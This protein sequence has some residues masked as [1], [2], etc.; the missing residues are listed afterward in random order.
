MTVDIIERAKEKEK[1]KAKVVTIA[2]NEYDFNIISPPELP[3]DERDSLVQHLLFSMYIKAIWKRGD[4]IIEGIYSRKRNRKRLLVN[5]MLRLVVRTIRRFAKFEAL[6]SSMEGLLFEQVSFLNT[7]DEMPFMIK[8]NAMDLN[9]THVYFNTNIWEIYKYEKVI[10]FD[11]KEEVSKKDV[12]HLLTYFGMVDYMI[13]ELK[14]YLLKNIRG[15]NFFVWK[16]RALRFMSSVQ[17]SQRY[18]SATL[19]DYLAY[20]DEE[21]AVGGD[22]ALAIAHQL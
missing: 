21:D 3:W 9:L 11:R 12:D 16:Q 18:T 22:A 19:L 7:P 8:G 14:T 2:A 15:H 20:L 5:K 10:D 1:A 17:K 6:R 13:K 4:A